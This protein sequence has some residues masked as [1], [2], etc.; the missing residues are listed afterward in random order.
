[1]RISRD[2]GPN[3][4]LEKINGPKICFTFR[5]ALPFVLPKS[6]VITIATVRHFQSRKSFIAKL[7]GLAA[8]VGL[9]PKLAAKSVARVA[10][11]VTAEP[12]TF[13]LKQDTRAVSR[14]SDS[15]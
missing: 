10:A 7:L 9:A 14:H 8:A 2:R 12:S 15:V 3:D 4:L 6:R 11:P 1:M 13:Q 5:K